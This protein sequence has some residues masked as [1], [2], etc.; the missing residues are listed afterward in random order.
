MRVMRF[1]PRVMR[2]EAI[3]AHEVLAAAGSAGR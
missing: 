3:S 1:E 2:G